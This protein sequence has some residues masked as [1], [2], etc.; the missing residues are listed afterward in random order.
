[1]LFKL[2]VDRDLP[3]N[4]CIYVCPNDITIVLFLRASNSLELV[5]C[6]LWYL[7]FLQ[8]YR[9]TP[10]LQ[11]RVLYILFE[12]SIRNIPRVHFDFIVNLVVASP[13]SPLRIT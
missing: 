3:G 6:T 2:H 11:L 13:H 8:I 7:L 5:F 10:H 9:Y 1:M 4:S 12:V